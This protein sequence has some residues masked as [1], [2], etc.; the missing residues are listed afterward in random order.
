MTMA[1][2]GL[3]VVDLSRTF[4]GPLSTMLL[5]DNGADVI[6]VE[7]PGAGDE[8]RGWSPFWN[9]HS[10]MFL[11]FNRNKRGITVNLKAP[12]GRDLI[13]DLAKNAD[14]FVESFRAGT[15]DKMGLGYEEVRAVNPRIVYCSISGYGRTGPYAHKP[16]YDLIL[17][18]FGGLISTTGNPGEPPV[19]IGYSTVDVTAGLVAYSGMMTALMARERTGQGQ[20]VEA[21][22]LEGQILTMGYHAISYFGTGLVP[23]PLGRGHPAIVPYQIF[24][25]S[26]GYFI[27]G[28]ANDGLW[29]RFCT[30][31]GLDHL[32]DDPKFAKNADRVTNRSELVGVLQEMFLKETRAYWV[33]KLESAGVPVGPINRVDEALNDPQTRARDMVVS[34]PHPDIPDFQTFGTPL[35]LEGTPGSIRRPPPRLGEHTDEVL[36]EYGFSPETINSLRSKGVI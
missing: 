12:E 34:I 22:L 18:G 26:D 17:Q 13:L 25:A 15:A 28:V 36:G 16:G 19:R 23:G 7:E 1:L 3:R 9:G 8:T 10:C 6:K 21:S 14:V 24:E 11:T 20:R 31:L 2:E 32:V 35:K 5:A 33:D 27:V 30:G 29:R 4:A